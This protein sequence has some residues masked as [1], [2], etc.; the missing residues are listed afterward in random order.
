MGAR[1]RHPASPTARPH[2]GSAHTGSHSHKYTLAQR[3]HSYRQEDAYT[4]SQTH[5]HT[6]RY[7][8]A[9]TLTQRNAYTQNSALTFIQI[10][11]QC[12]LLHTKIQTHIQ[13]HTSTGN[14]ART[15]I[16]SPK[17]TFT[18]TNH[19]LSQ[20]HTSTQHRHMHTTTL[21]QTTHKYTPIRNTF[22]LTHSRSNTFT[23]ANS[24]TQTY[25]QE[26]TYTHEHKCT[27]TF[28]QI[29]K[30]RLIHKHLQTYEYTFM[31]ILT[32]SRTHSHIQHTHLPHPRTHTIPECV[33]MAV[34]GVPGWLCITGNLDFSARTCT[35]A[36]KAGGEG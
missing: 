16:S 31:Q 12:A 20:I 18:H 34:G 26:H 1:R 36:F 19:T 21:I 35:V 23:Q 8:H 4:Q 24:H 10:H 2:T 7:I 14:Y 6:R 28:T 30:Y 11:P 9:N 3:S 32:L 22:I 25:T 29:Y 33:S 17:H 5:T 13:I 15:L 27:N